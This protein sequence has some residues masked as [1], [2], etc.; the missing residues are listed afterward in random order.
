VQLVQP[1][2]KE[3]IMLNPSRIASR[4]AGACV[5]ALALLSPVHAAPVLQMST[6]TSASGIDLTV[7]AQDVADLYG[8]QFTLNFD[9]ALLKALAGTEGAFLPSGGSTFFDPGSIDNITGSISFVLGTLI[10]AIDGVDGSGD[11]ATFSFDVLQGGFANFSFSDVFLLD[12]S[13][14]EISVE[15]RGL[16]AQVPEPAT[17]WLTAI[18]LFAV[19]GAWTRR[20]RTL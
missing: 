15:A 9:P 4:A 5:L 7:R 18:G 12:S 2:N 20:P 14:A 6:A 10:G 16:V 3:I 13:F 11:L 1:S 19:L 17:L 8:Y